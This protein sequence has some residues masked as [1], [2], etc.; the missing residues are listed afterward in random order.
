M[1]LSE[2]IGVSAVYGRGEPGWR[3]VNKIY[4]RKVTPCLQ[5]VLIWQTGLIGSW[6]IVK[7]QIIFKELES[8]FLT[9]LDL[10]SILRNVSSDHFNIFYES[11]RTFELF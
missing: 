10:L 5:L 6:N 3:G 1:N 4:K 8:A 7:V 9:K 2:G 11:R